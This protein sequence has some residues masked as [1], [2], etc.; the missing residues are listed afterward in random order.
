MNEI[1]GPVLSGLE[2]NRLWPE[3]Q[4]SD[5]LRVSGLTNPLPSF[6]M[7][8]SITLIAFTSPGSAETVEA[9]VF[10][11][12]PGSYTAA[13]TVS[14]GSS[15]PGASINYT[16]DGTTP[17]ATVGTL[18]E[19]TT[20]NAIAYATGMTDSSVTTATYTISP[21]VAAPTFSP[22]AGT[23][24]SGQTWLSSARPLARRSAT[25]PTEARRARR[26]APF[27]HGRSPWTLPP[28]SKPSPTRPG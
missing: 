9:P 6:F 24:G 12:A 1:I 20:I 4:N 25:P 22:A 5:A 14:I 23:Y 28:L 3:G 10:T 13:Q 26:R 21:L 17:T 15:A 8:L 27:I 2:Y 16:T 18:R 19:T 11:P 7:R